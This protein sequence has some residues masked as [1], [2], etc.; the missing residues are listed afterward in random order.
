MAARHEHA[1]NRPVQTDNTRVQ[2]D[3]AVEVLAHES[4]LRLEAAEQL[5]AVTAATAVTIRRLIRGGRRRPRLGHALVLLKRWTTAVTT[6]A[7]VTEEGRPQMAHPTLH[8]VDRS[9]HRPHVRLAPRQSGERQRL[10]VGSG[11]RWRKRLRRWRLRRRALAFGAL[12]LHGLVA[13]VLTLLLR[14]LRLLRLL[15]QLLSLL[16]LQLPL[17]MRR[18]RLVRRDE[19]EGGQALRRVW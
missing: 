18:L 7:V 8:T 3:Q 17:V 6:A 9:N 19:R 15:L 12:H 10:R 16:L 4:L 11:R 14:L 5:G 13:V 1:T 2:L